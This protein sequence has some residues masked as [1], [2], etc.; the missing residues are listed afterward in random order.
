MNLTE[1][2]RIFHPTAAEYIL[3]RSHGNF[4]KTEHILGHAA[5]PNKCRKVK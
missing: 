2:C 3:L 4:S 1:I 5:S